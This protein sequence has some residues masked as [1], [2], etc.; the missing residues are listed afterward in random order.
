LWTLSAKPGVV[1][2]MIERLLPTMLKLEMFAR[3]SRQ[4]GIA[5][6]MNWARLKPADARKCRSLLTS[7]QSVYRAGWP[8]P[9][10]DAASGRVWRPET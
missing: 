10:P 7:R 4:T 1:Y 2:E 8:P 3:Q 5:G 6:A 9:W